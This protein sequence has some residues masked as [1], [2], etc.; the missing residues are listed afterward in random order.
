MRDTGKE[1]ID[2]IPFDELQRARNGQAIYRPFNKR[3]ELKGNLIIRT[4]CLS[5]KKVKKRGKE[6]QKIW[7]E[8]LIDGRT[9][10]QVE[11]AIKN[12]RYR[13]SEPFA[14]IIRAVWVGY[15]RLE[16]G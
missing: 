15:I 9:V 3:Y 1:I 14:D 5:L 11:R 12:G 2:Y 7:E 13:N 4:T 6:R 8:C 16:S 10:D